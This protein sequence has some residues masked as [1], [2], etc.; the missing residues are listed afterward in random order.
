M[1]QVR[2]EEIHADMT[3]IF[4]II[5]NLLKFLESFELKYHENPAT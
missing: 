5:Q 3:N 2:S 1:R 4:V